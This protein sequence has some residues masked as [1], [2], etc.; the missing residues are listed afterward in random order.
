MPSSSAGLTLGLLPALPWLR[1]LMLLGRHRPPQRLRKID[2]LPYHS[3]ASSCLKYKKVIRSEP[4]W[5]GAATAA[6]AGRAFA[7]PR[8]R[9]SSVSSL[10]VL[11]RMRYQKGLT[12]RNH[13]ASSTLGQRSG[14]G[15]HHVCITSAVYLQL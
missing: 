4:S 2:L 10:E 15:M 5:N 8:A 11:K 6:T 3:S 7:A 12:H 14:A 9:A 1:L 13:Q